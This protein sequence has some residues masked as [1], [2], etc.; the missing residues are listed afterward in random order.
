[1]KKLL[2][3]MALTGLV[4]FSYAETT[5]LKAVSVDRNVPDNGVLRN[6]FTWSDSSLQTVSSVAVT[7]NF[8]SPFVSNPINL[9]HLSASLRF[10][11]SS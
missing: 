8:S 11:I 5:L 4:F 6:G 7:L 9:N 3:V 1:M 2:A 10:G